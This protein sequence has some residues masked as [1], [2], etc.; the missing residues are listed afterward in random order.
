MGKPILCVDFDGVIHSYEN[1][2]QNGEIYGTVV[3][4]FFEWLI[5]AKDIFAIVIYSSRSKDPEMRSDMRKWLRSKAG[6]HGLPVDMDNLVEFANEKP[7]AYLTIDD[8]AVCFKGD[9]NAPELRPDVLRAFA[10]WNTKE[11]ESP[12]QE[13]IVIH[14]ECESCKGT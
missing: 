4:G 11:A 8:R 9:W 13:N 7:A 10:P 3:P 6:Y 2:W 5:K 14:Y 1:G 12:K